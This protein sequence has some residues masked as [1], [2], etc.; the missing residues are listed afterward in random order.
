MDASPR[1]TAADS[2]P[3]MCAGTHRVHPGVARGNPNGLALCWALPWGGRASGRGGSR[4]ISAPSS[5]MCWEPRTALKK[6]LTVCLQKEALMPHQAVERWARGCDGQ[7]SPPGDG[8]AG[9]A[10]G[11]T[12]WEP[13][14]VLGGG[15]QPAYLLSL[16]VPRGHEEG[17]VPVW[18]VAGQL[19]CPHQGPT[20]QETPLQV[21]PADTGQTKPGPG[22]GGGSQHMG[23]G[24]GREQDTPPRG[25]ELLSQSWD[26]LRTPWSAQSTVPRCPAL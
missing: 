6:Y 9:G 19:V 18:E 3:H 22:G 12:W 23:P 10:P 2:R 11:R 5:Q 16:H 4:G 24:R 15:G 21:A 8:E 26:S 7:E 14:A 25:R 20:R 1:C 13:S 17:H